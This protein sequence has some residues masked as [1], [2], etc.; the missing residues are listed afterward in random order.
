MLRSFELA[1]LV[2][3]ASGCNFHEDKRPV[4]QALYIEDEAPVGYAEVAAEVLGPACF[5]CHGAGKA[6]GGVALDTYEGAAAE[7]AAIREVVFVKQS[8]PP[9]GRLHER[10]ALLLRVWLDAG[11]PETV[12]GDLN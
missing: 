12:E 10:E 5:R 11:T 3:L 1:V 2:T 4:R 9:G 6:L 7:A 8:M